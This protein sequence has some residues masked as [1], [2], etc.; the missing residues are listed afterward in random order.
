VKRIIFSLYR[1]DLSDHDSVP[2]F[3]RQQFIKYADLLEKKHREYAKQV[4]ADYILIKPDSTD[5]IDVQFQKLL[6]FEKLANSYDELMYIDF[7]VIPNTSVNMFDK[8]NTD[9]ICAFDI[10]VQSIERKELKARLKEDF[11]WHSMDMYTKAHNKKAMLLLHDI[12]GTQSCINTAVV[13]MNSKCVRNLNFAERSTEA[14]ETFNNALIDNVYPEALSKSWVLNNEVIF[15]YI[16]EKYNLPFT[17]IGMPWNFILDHN[18]Q[19]M[20]AAAHF[21]HFVHKK[22]DLFFDFR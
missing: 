2:T 8:F 4:G 17:N 10:Q 21:L 7:D 15:S 5:Y 19:N 9:S 13:L 22:F 1:N 12:V 18:E 11:T 6:T 20:T 16:I 3:K 14:I